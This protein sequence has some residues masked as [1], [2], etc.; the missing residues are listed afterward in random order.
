M[1]GV[2]RKQPDTLIIIWYKSNVGAKLQ[3]EKKTRNN[4]SRY[5][6]QTNRLKNTEVKKDYNKDR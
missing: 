3:K 4:A 6:L 1:L 5:K 2:T